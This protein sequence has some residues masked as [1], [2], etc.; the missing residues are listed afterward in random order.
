[1]AFGKECVPLGRASGLIRRL[2]VFEGLG[3]EGGVYDKVSRVWEEGPEAFKAREWAAG[4]KE[5]TG[6]AP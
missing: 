5:R 4:C 1:M 2:G 3:R 6:M